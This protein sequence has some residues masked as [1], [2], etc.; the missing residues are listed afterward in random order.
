MHSTVISLANLR[1]ATHEPLFIVKRKSFLFCSSKF[2]CI[3]LGHNFTR[4]RGRKEARREGENIYTEERVA[5]TAKS[6]K[7]YSVLQWVEKNKL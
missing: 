3:L 6:N 7:I 1:H 2:N 5:A 4:E